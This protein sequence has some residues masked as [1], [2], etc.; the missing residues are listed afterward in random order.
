M[1]LWGGRFKGEMDAGAWEMN[2]SISVDRRLAEQDIQGS[3]AWAGALKKAGVLSKEDH[4]QIQTGL[5]VVRDE[6]NTGT[7]EL[8]AL[9]EDIH[10]AVER[11]L[12][13]LCGPAAGKLH[14]GRSR[15]DQVAT[16]LRLW[17]LERLPELDEAMGGLQSALLERAEK[18]FGVLMPGYTHLQRAQPVLLSHWWLSHFWPLQRDRQRLRDMRVRTASLPL[19]SG[20]LAGVPF[21]IDREALANELGFDGP[22]PNSIDGVADRDF[23]AEFLFCCALCG[24]HLSR[25]SEAL[26]IFSSA[27]FGFFQFSDAFTSGSSLMPQKKNPDVFELTRGRTGRLIGYVSGLLS[28]LK[29]LPSAYDKDLQEDKLPVFN[30]FDLLVQVLP[31]LAEALRT[32]TTYPA[33]LQVNL[34]P[35]MM[36][37]DAADYLVEKGVPFREAHTL[38][39]AAVR[40]AASKGVEVN[41]LSI[42]EL[43]SIHPGFETDFY[44]VFD[45]QRSVSRRK[46]TGGTAP[47][48]VREQM[49]SCRK[50]VEQK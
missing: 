16:D 7:F 47:E 44:E 46:A 11:R 2:A 17:M 30:A 49:E 33:R 1:K 4:S 18:D 24:V 43:H 8:K 42:E 25:M 50:L 41:Q 23:A 14:T 5:A 45:P 48:A 9:D 34:D 15:N 22:T 10:T 35:G 26:I 27:E 37:A 40:M 6:F 20:A 29:G 12:G 13:E 21:P 39:G 36:A 3:L 31:V 28:T 32:L 38:I 19:G